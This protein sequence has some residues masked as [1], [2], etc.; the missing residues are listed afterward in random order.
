MGSEKVDEVTSIFDV[1]TKAM[2]SV[3]VPTTGIATFAW[4]GGGLSA[5]LIEISKL[6]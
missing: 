1:P 5:S 2:L 3:S 4:P 6:V